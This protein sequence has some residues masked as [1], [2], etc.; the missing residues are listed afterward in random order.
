[1]IIRNNA[2]GYARLPGEC[3]FAVPS[4]QPISP[5]GTLSS[6]KTVLLLGIRGRAL[7]AC[8]RGGA[9]WYDIAY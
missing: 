5:M 4:P 7:A 8:T 1:M 2:S 3:L 9:L 6:A